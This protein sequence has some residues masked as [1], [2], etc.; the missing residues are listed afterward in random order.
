MTHAFDARALRRELHRHPELSGSEART[1][2]IIAAQLEAFA[3]DALITE[4]GGEG[5]AAVFEG[6]DAGPTVLVRCEL[7]A[8]PIHEHGAPAHRSEVDGC[9]HMC[10]HDGHM[11]IVTSVAA[12]LARRRP[13]RGRV[14][15]LYQPAEETGAGAAAIVAD[16]EYAALRPDVALALHNVPGEPLGHVFVSR[17]PANCASRGLTVDFVGR[18]AHAAHPERGA[19]PTGAM[20]A[21]I[22]TLESI[23]EHVAL[24]DELAFATVVGASLGEHAFGTAPGAARVSVTLR[25]ETNATMA[26]LVAFVTAHAADLARREALEVTLA[27]HDIFGAVVNTDGAVDALCEA[28]PAGDVTVTAQGVRWSEDF[29]V[30]IAD[31]GAGALIRLG[32]GEDTP[33]LHAPDYDFPDALT[34]IGARIFEAWIAE[35]LKRQW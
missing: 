21:L 28:L 22:E 10:G 32:A 19:R 13:L 4:L 9:G 16:P 18:T 11:A 8:L 12:G 20:C 24:G 2:A 33:D 29:G 31:A 6:A 15:L 27:Q 26:R 34:P 1:A 23:G 30:L 25:S 5:V 14:V 17:G 35:L 7:D 3:P